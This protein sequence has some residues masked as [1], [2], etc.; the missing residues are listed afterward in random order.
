M[1]NCKN[2]KHSVE[3]DDLFTPQ[4]M[5]IGLLLLHVPLPNFNQGD[6]K[7]DNIESIFYGDNVDDYDVCTNFE[8]K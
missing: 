2:C 5:A 8:S 1:K 6:L 4:S 3:D 7:C